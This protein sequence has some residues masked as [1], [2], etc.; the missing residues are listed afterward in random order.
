M[1]YFKQ[2]VLRRSRTTWILYYM[3]LKKLNYLPID[4]N[5]LILKDY[6]LINDVFVN[7][8]YLKFTISSYEDWDYNAISFTFNDVMKYEPFDIIYVLN[9][10][11]SVAYINVL[12]QKFKYWGFS[13]RITQLLKSYNWYKIV[14]HNQIYIIEKNWH[15]IDDEH[16]KQQLTLT[17]IVLPYK[18]EN[19]HINVTAL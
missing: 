2:L 7:N 15:N 8:D 12:L 1:T 3:I 13:T 4:V 16:F 9:K 18:G 11:L 17:Y 10:H 19:I 5:L 6:I 14:I